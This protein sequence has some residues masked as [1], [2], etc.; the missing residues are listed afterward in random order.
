M[1][2]WLAF[3]L[4]EDAGDSTGTPTTNNCGSTVGICSA[5]ITADSSKPYWDG[6]SCVSCAAGTENAK[7]FL[8]GSQCVRECTNEQSVSADDTTCVAS[9]SKDYILVDS[10]GIVHKKCRENWSCTSEGYEYDDPEAKETICV[11][12]RV[13]T[14]D[15]RM[16]RLTNVSQLPRRMRTN[17]ISL[18]ERTNA[19]TTSIFSLEKTAQSATQS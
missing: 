8:D 9:C 3:V 2:P 16:L 5:C 17:S 12:A 15:M 1:F 7:P 11:S 4:L 10:Y 18:T 19:K 6:D 14:K 13:A